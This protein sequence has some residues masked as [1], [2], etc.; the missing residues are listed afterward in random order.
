MANENTETSGHDVRDQA[1]Q[2]TLA[3][4][5]LVG[6][7]G[8]DILDSARTLLGHMASNPH[9][10]ATVSVLPRRARPHRDRRLRARAR[11]QGQAFCR[12]G[13]EGELCLPGARAVP[14]SPGAGAL[15][16]FV[17]E[18]KM[19]KRDAERARFIV[20]LL[21]RRDVAD[22]L[23]RGQSRGAE[24]ARRHLAARASCTA[25]RILSATSRATAACRR[26]STRGNSPWARISQRHRD[27]SSTAT[28]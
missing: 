9:G 4:N 7:R 19:D 27:R 13:V 10:G 23:A 2:H 15:N 28:R 17:D 8:R 5:P 1:A 24:E 16:R 22:Q 21:G 11:S 20:S 6:V 25:W 18:A 26:R 3:A 12:S 14:T